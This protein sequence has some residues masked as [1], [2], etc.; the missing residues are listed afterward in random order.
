MRYS[1]IFLLTVH[2]VIAGIDCI[3]MF[4]PLAKP[5]WINVVPEKDFEHSVAFLSQPSSQSPLSI[6]YDPYFV[7]LTT[8]YRRRFRSRGGV[9]SRSLVFMDI[10]GVYA[11]KLGRCTPI[12]KGCTRILRLKKRINPGAEIETIETINVTRL[13]V[14]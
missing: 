13:P 11:Y 4:S 6:Q 12:G 7:T 5:G 2:I 3:G 14:V 9:T 1:D 8:I 10:R